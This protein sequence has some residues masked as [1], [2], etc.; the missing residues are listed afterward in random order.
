[1]AASPLAFLLIAA[2]A[3]ATGQDGPKGTESGQCAVDTEQM[4]QLT[5]TAFDQDMNGGWRT[6]ASRSGCEKAAAN[7]IESY[8]RHNWHRL[9]QE[10]LHVMYWHEGQMEAIAGDNHLAI[11]LLMA[12]VTP[13]KRR[14]DMGFYEY[15]LGTVAFLNRDLPGLKAARQRLA[16]LPEPPWFKAEFKGAMAWPANLNVLDGL[17]RCFDFPYAVA[18]GDSCPK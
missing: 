3:S 7:L 9:D 10:N 12:G 5:P 16:A 1:M 18:Y 8:I 11:P 15:S 14:L 13:D 17:I 6:L 4:M 2:I